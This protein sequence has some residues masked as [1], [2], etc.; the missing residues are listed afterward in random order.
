MLSEALEAT[1]AASPI[2][3]RRFFVAAVARL[4]GVRMPVTASKMWSDAAVQ[5]SDE[6]SIVSEQ[7]V[8]ASPAIHGWFEEGAQ[9][10]EWPCRRRASLS[11][12]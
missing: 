7:Y 4:A 9:R 3:P 8:R 2:D 1:A 10:S 5:C 12:A 11:Y 6:M